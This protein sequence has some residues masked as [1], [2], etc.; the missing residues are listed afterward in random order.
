MKKK[1]KFQQIAEVTYQKVLKDHA[2]YFKESWTKPMF[3]KLQTIKFNKDG[4]VKKS[5]YS[6]ILT[7]SYKTIYLRWQELFKEA[8]DYV[9][10]RS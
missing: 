3:E 8:K 1:T 10:N 2:H 4:N 5:K 7:F 6:E 9:K